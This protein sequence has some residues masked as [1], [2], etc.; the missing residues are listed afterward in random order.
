MSSNFS[1][2][3][4]G[5]KG[6]KWTNKIFFNPN[7]DSIILCEFEVKSIIF[8]IIEDD[9]GIYGL[10][11]DGIGIHY[12]IIEDTEVE[13]NTDIYYIIYDYTQIEDSSRNQCHQDE[14]LLNCLFYRHLDGPI[15]SCAID[16]GLLMFYVFEDSEG[17]HCYIED[18]TGI[19]SLIR[20]DPTMSDVCDDKQLMDTFNSL[21]DTEENI[22]IIHAYKHKLSEMQ[23]TSFLIYHLFIVVKTA[24]WWWSIEKNSEGISIQRS[25][26][27][28]AV[29]RLIRQ[30]NRISSITLVKESTGRRSVGDLIRWL[31]KENEFHKRYHFLFSNCQTFA[32]R[33]FNYVAECS[34]LYWFDGAFS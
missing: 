19:Y 11:E 12:L 29:T 7:A 14:T 16:D 10:I 22:E 34:N 6:N 17:I 20:G 24:N 1:S 25:K 30:E 28:F 18:E 33:V 23:L 4:G 26:N 3:S 32:K 13:Y 8:S 21:V 2:S 15:C 31:K 9:T 27:Q 5:S